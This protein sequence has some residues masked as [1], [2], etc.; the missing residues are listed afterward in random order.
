MSLALW[1][2]QAF[3]VEMASP[4]AAPVTMDLPFLLR[5]YVLND[6]AD[7]PDCTVSGRACTR[8]SSLVSPSLAHSM[9]MGWP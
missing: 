1:I 6:V 2:M 7:L 5:L 8:N 4:M 3:P 9:S